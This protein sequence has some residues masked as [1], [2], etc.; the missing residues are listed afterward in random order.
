MHLSDRQTYTAFMNSTITSY[1]CFTQESLLCQAL[2][3]SHC[4]VH[5]NGGIGMT[6][7]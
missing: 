4:R 6:K 7:G 3:L 1:K 5:E 2:R